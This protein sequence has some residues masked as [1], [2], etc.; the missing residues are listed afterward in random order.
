M[1]RTR[2]LLLL[3]AFMGRTAVWSAG[4]T[5]DADIAKE[6]KEIDKV[7]AEGDWDTAWESLTQHEVPEWFADAK[8]G[9]YAH[10]GV[11]CVPAFGTEWYPRLMYQEDQKAFAHHRQTYGDQT[12]FGY[13][14]FVPM[15][16]LDKFDPAEWAQLYKDAG[17]KFA[18]PVAEHHDGFSMWASTVN[19][20]N[21]GQMGPKRDIAGELIREL[22]RRDLKIITSFHHAFNI[23]GYYTA[24]EGWD[25]GDPQYGDLYGFPTMEDRTL[26]RNRW[27]IK[28]KEVIDRYQPD[29]IWFDFGLAKMPDDYKQRMAA[30]YYNHEKIWGKPVIITR[31]G[32]HLPEGVG[33]LD[34]ERGWTSGIAAD[35]WQTDDSAA[36]NSWSWVQGLRVKT[37]TEMVHEL[38]DIVSKNGVLL[39]NVCPKADGTITEDQQTVLREMGRWLKVNGE[40]IYATRPWE[41]YGEGPTH[42]EKEGGFLETMQYTPHDIRYTRSKDGKTLYAIAMGWPG[43]SLALRFVEIDRLAPGA[44]VTLLGHD[45]PLAFNVSDSKQLEIR[46]P[47]LVDDARPCRHAYAFKI[48]GFETGL[49]P[50]ARFVLPG[51]VT[52]KAENAVLEGQKIG[53]EE[54]STGITNIGFWDNPTERVHWLLYVK[55]AGAYNA[56]GEFATPHSE[57]L[58]TVD[59][60]DQRLPFTVKRTGNWDKPQ[61]TEI[62]TVRFD[63][64]G[65][66][67]LVLGATD[68]NNW[69]AVNVW[70]IKLAPQP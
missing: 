48:S 33:A 12:E 49:S 37:P 58:L 3:I 22:R 25:T 20:W 66:Y 1:T 57:S 54:K 26:A 45:E 23:Q 70:D 60:A 30:Y 38:I 55:K 11:Y 53:T 50:E 17:A 31:K 15:F 6:L 5:S 68:R 34:I 67:H 28:L 10:L 14:D 8:F 69:R 41:V 42:T 2:T 62:G 24:K 61:M 47:A 56:V 43:K 16:K 40:A 36:H 7:N 39:L 29:Q 52:L 19:R 44:K 64:P 13:K 59:V 35:L 9:I 51:V 63:Q 4:V 46:V 21:V 65:V 32:D 18:G 27:L